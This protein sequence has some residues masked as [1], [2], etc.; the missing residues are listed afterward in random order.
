MCVRQSCVTVHKLFNLSELP[1]LHILRGGNDTPRMAISINIQMHAYHSVICSTYAVPTRMIDI[2]GSCTS[3][4]SV[5]L[6]GMSPLQ[7]L[8]IQLSLGHLRQ[9]LCCP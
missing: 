8:F 4:V 9:L 2:F 7:M 1:F 5:T 6:K 3:M